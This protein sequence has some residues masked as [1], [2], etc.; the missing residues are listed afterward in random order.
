MN[1]TLVPIYELT[2]VS[3]VAFFLQKDKRISF[4]DFDNTTCFPIMIPPYDAIERKKQFR[5]NEN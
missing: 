2:R 3:C 4:T 5:S 1:H